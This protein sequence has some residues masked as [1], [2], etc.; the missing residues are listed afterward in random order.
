MET[1]V[2]EN[3]TMQ[4]KRI[5][6]ALDASAHSQAAMDAAAGIAEL[7]EAELIG[8]FVEDINLVRVAQLPF[9]REVQFPVARVAEID[10]PR[11]EGQLREL[12]AQVRRQL[13]DAASHHNVRW[14]FR[15][16][17]GR[18]ATELLSAALEADLLAL[19]RSGRSLVGASRLGSTV[20]TA[21]AESRGSLLIM[22][23]GVDL[24]APILTIYDGTAGARRALAAAA[25]LAQMS[26]RLHVLIHAATT[27]E[28]Q[29]YRQEIV[30]L[31]HLDGDDAPALE[32]SYRRMHPGDE[33]RLLEI[34]ADSDV[35]M[36]VLGR[37]ATAV[38]SEAFT[39]LL[40]HLTVPLLLVR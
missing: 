24:D 8:V 1:A 18:V 23:A 20:R 38:A 12:A 34:V 9:V 29:Q 26:G 22:R 13:R 32:L 14:S 27:A 6:V 17:R 40:E 15:V 16:Q 7:L 37:Q 31:T 21:V 4:I 3:D 39:E 5:I 33:A 19:G 30:H 11:M 25:M 10:E 28:A 2:D 36:L 35:G